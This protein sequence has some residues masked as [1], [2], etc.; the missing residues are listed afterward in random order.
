VRVWNVSANR[1]ERRWRAHSDSIHGLA[2]LADGRV[3]SASHDASLALWTPDGTLLARV[4]S[5]SPILDLD[6]AEGEGLLH[7]AHRDGTVRAWRV[8]GL[9]AVDRVR[10]HRGRVRAVAFHAPSGR[11]ASSGSDG[12]VYVWRDG[13]TPRRLT[14]PP[15]DARD[16]VFTRD[17]ETLLGAG[18][19]KLFRWRL[20][21]GSLEVVP[22]PH[23]GIIASLALAPDGRLASIS[24]QTDSAV[25]LSNPATEGNWLRLAPHELCGTYVRLSPDGRFLA[26]TSDDATV[27]VWDLHALPHALA[28]GGR[29]RAQ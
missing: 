5:D 29:V 17:G 27:Q 23:R 2:A 24:R 28:A 6:V 9:R 15:T 21:D 20:A 19:F 22:T 10:L 1:E 16:L 8:D 26:S 7:T 14:P 4:H 13:E 12:E 11:L 25:Y 18:W 3:L